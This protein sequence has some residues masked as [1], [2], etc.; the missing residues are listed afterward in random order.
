MVNKAYVDALRQYSPQNGVGVSAPSISA[1][2]IVRPSVGNLASQ[3]GIV[4]PAIDRFG[5]IRELTEQIE[6]G[7]KTL[8]LG[9]KVQEKGQ[10]ASGYSGGWGPS[11]YGVTGRTG[12][13]N[14]KGA[15][16]Y[17][18]QSPFWNALQRANADMKAA[19]LGSFGITDGWRSYAAQVAVKKK[20][21]NLAAT[22]GRSVHGLGY[23]ADLR[24]SRAQQKWLEKNGHRY[25]IARLPSESWHWQY[26]PK[27]G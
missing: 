8:A 2:G 25:G 10:Q 4:A 3:S 5:K 22:P 21:G 20:K 1:P 24:L 6:V 27:K 18:L 13:A 17:G 9:E 15:A 23:A 7:K 11:A 16:P 14:Q 19:G 12:L 26:T